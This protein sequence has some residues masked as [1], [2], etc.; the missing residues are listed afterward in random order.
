[1]AMQVDLQ[2]PIY[3][4]TQNTGTGF[5]APF[6]GSVAK[7]FSS[8]MARQDSDLAMQLHGGYGFPSSTRWSDSAVTRMAGHWRAV[9]R[10]SSGC[11]SPPST[12]LADSINEPERSP[13]DRA[14]RGSAISISRP[15]SPCRL[16][17]RIGGEPQTSGSARTRAV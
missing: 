7:C 13:T 3:R 4:A 10:T 5:P 6:A 9:L 2:T 1:M 16:L 8:E 12:S 15:R 17:P 11:G 14:R